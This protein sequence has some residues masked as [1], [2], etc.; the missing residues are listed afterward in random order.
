MAAA[1]DTL[2]YTR[3]FEE[4]GVSHEEAIRLAE[5]ARDMIIQELVTQDTLRTE[6][7]L[8]RAE[9]N[10][11]IATPRRKSCAPSLLLSLGLYL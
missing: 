7:K 5:P 1:F 11:D 8:L 6:L 3:R 10:S 2:R 9:V 4:V